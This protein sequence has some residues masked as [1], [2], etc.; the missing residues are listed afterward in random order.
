[1][2]GLRI[3][4]VPVKGIVGGIPRATLTNAFMA[5]IHGGRIT[6]VDMSAESSIWSQVKGRGKKEESRKMKSVV[7]FVR[8]LSV[9]RAT[10]VLN[11]DNSIVLSVY[12]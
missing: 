4:S 11:D 5:P 2:R 6:G 1:M 8:G 12:A 3:A 10:S 9:G 7:E